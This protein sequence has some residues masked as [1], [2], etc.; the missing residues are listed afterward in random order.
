MTIATY[1]K[2]PLYISVLCV[3]AFL[4]AGFNHCVA[5]S[6]YLFLQLGNWYAWLMF[7]AVVLGNLIGGYAIKKEEY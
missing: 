6:F 7:I 1:K 4:M 3:M 2:T 5:D